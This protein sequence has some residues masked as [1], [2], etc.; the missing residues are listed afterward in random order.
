MLWEEQEEEDL[1][2]GV[3]LGLT[4]KQLAEILG[5]TDSSI[6]SKKQ[7]LLLNLDSYRGW[8]QEEIEY[9]NKYYEIEGPKYCANALNRTS[10]SCAKK[11][12]KLGL[13]RVY[14]TDAEVTFLK[15]NYLEKGAT[16]CATELRKSFGS[17][18]RKAERL[19]LL[20]SCKGGKKGGGPC[21][22]YLISFPSECLYKIGITDNLQRRKSEFGSLDS[23]F[24]YTKKCETRAVARSLEIETLKAVQK[25]MIN[26]GVL[27]NGNTETFSMSPQV[28]ETF[29]LKDYFE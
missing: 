4:D 16:F 19:G 29:S 20:S 13:K 25:Y 22:L 17:T 14:W 3:S 18:A 21:F 9:L 24:I 15:E 12:E 23:C 28:F 2:L 8:T 27:N 1:K 10:K 5:K 26:T 11:A 7:R 6:R